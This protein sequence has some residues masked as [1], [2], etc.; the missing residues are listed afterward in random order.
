MDAY[1][2]VVVG[3]D[4]VWNLAHPWYRYC[5]L[6]Y[7]DGLRTKRMIS[8]AASFGNYQAAWG[9]EKDWASKLL[10]FDH[11]SVRDDNSSKIITD[12]LGIKPDMVLDPC[13]QF[14]INY[15]KRDLSHISR[16]YVAVYG[17]NFSPFFI[18]EVRAW[19]KQQQLPLISIGYRNDWADENWLTADP[20]DFANF[21]ANAQAAVTNF[22]H[23]CVF[24]VINKK[25]FVCETSEYRSIKVQG[26]MKKL[27]ADHHLIMEGTPAEVY[28]ARLS[29][30]LNPQVQE[31]I[32]MLRAQSNAYLDIALAPK[33]LELS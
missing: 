3:S 23:G 1:D 32:E 14:P 25:P 4:E 7:G 16:P 24:S 18:E 17:H 8:Y 10:K 30:P 31:R 11:I 22:F 26:L 28:H 19:A 12:A 21:M 9:L 27:G 6:F 15:E 20:H 13:L 33:L 2:L 5:P 29:E